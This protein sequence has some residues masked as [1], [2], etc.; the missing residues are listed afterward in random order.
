MRSIVRDRFEIEHSTVQ[1]EEDD[2]CSEGPC[3]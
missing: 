1:L 3:G 2:E